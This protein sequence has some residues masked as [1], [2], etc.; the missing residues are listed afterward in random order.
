MS[1]KITPPPFSAMALDVGEPTTNRIE[2]N[3]H[4]QPDGVYAGEIEPIIGRL[5][6]GRRC[7]HPRDTADR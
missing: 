2:Q 1:L 6:R 7:E 4:G 5:L 3:H